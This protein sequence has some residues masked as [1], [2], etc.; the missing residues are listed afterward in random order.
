MEK[1]NFRPAGRDYRRVYVE[2]TDNDR[3]AGILSSEFPILW[4][5]RRTA[6]ILKDCSSS[7]GDAKKPAMRW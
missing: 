5:M 2:G 7:R 3:E 1:L 6:Y 4:T